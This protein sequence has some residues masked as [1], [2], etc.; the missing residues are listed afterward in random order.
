MRFVMR[1]F[2]KVPHCR[3]KRKSFSLAVVASRRK[4]AVR[5]KPSRQISDL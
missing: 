4:G 3:R 2:P 5:E 1:A